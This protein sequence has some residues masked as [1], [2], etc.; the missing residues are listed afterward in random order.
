MLP[1]LDIIMKDKSDCIPGRPQCLIVAP[2]REL[3]IQIF[4]EARKFANSSWVKV[5][6]AY[7]G[8]ASRHQGE[9]ISR[10][11]HVLVATPGRLM[12]FVNKSMVSFQDLKF[13]VLDEADRMLDMGFKE[14]ISSIKDHNSFNK[15]NVQ[16]LMFSAT[17]PDLIQRLASEYL[18]DYIFLTIGILGSASTDVEQEFIEVERIKKRHK[19]AVI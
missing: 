18:L 10:G 15:E 6:I 13:L 14:T 5:S 11:C 4:E 12:D 1:I 16:T 9:S 17:F 3:V 8:A 19:L 2:T 7:G